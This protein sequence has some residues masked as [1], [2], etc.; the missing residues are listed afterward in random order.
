[1]PTSSRRKSRSQ[2]V[3]DFVLPDLKPG[4]ISVDDV[5]QAVEQAQPQI[6]EARLVA[7][8]RLSENPDNPRQGM[9]E[10]PLRELASSIAERGLLQPLVVRRD[11]LRAGHYI[12]VAGSRRLLAARLV[13]GDH[14][15]MV[16]ARVAQLPCIIR[17]LDDRDAFADAL[18]ENLARRDLTRVEMMDA[19]LRLH[20]DYGWSAGYMARRTGR[21]Q[22]D[23]SELLRVALDP[24]LSALVKQD[25]IKPTV[26]G[27]VTRL[28]QDMR[29]AV[30]GDLQ[31]GTLK[32]VADVK[33]RR[34]DARQAK[35]EEVQRDRERAASA[36]ESAVLD[37]AM[38]GPARASAAS[39]IASGLADGATEPSDITWFP[40]GAADPPI[41][42]PAAAPRE[43]PKAGVT[44][45]DGVVS[46]RV[47]MVA[48]H[49]RR[50]V[51]HD[52]EWVTEV[53]RAA[54]RIMALLGA[55]KN[56]DRAS[57]R[58]LGELSAHIAAYLAT[59]ETH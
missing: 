25:I 34:A 15:E 24:A 19:V 54:A 5:A 21:N 41:A 31:A 22:H 46:E 42:R 10:G 32:T 47:V 58:K 16:R 39:G 17:G 53:E 23:L 43:E 4:E 48:A 14:D 28:P 8:D 52:L 56:P 37:R 12:V 50:L 11:P 57:L 35:D 29:D 40:A 55:R 2:S 51:D 26:A 20:Q 18:M 44:S 1:M 36:A 6:V 45:E 49:E 38:T 30:I 7:L 33:R 3:L 9:G 13:Y 27:E 59:Y